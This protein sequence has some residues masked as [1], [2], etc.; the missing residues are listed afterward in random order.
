M[1]AR[2]RIHASRRRSPNTRFGR[3][4]SG[5]GEGG[6]EGGRGT[7]GSREAEKGSVLYKRD[8]RVEAS[9][10]CLVKPQL[11]TYVY[12]DVYILYTKFTYT[13]SHTYSRIHTKNTDRQTDRQTDSLNH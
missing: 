13:I 6:R 5:G 12:M 10:F 9:V 8:L 7:E 1:D 2:A 4:V 3:E 11:L